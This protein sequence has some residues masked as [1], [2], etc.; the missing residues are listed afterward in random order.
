MSIFKS[1]TISAMSDL[2][3]SDPLD[4]AQRERFCQLIAKGESSQGQCYATA[5]SRDEL[6]STA[7]V[8]ASRLLRNAKVSARIQ[9]LK[10]LQG[11]Q[12]WMLATFLA[13]L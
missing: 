3:R 13:A 9:T 5:Y 6:D 12:L 4:N 7:Y 11:W 2:E 10:E 8:N 1:V